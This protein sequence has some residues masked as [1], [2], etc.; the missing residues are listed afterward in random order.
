MKKLYI[1]FIL[2]TFG[3]SP[4][5][6]A[7][8]TLFSDD[9]ESGYVTDTSIDGIN[10]WTKSE[11]GMTIKTMNS[12]GN[13]NSSSDWYA[14]YTTG[15]FTIMQIDFNVEA[16]K[17]YTFK[18]YSYKTG[19]GAT[20]VK[21]IDAQAVEVV[22]GPTSGTADAWVERKETFVASKTETLT[23]QCVQNWGGGTI[24]IDDV[25]LIC[26]DCTP[27]SIEKFNAFE[28][29]AYP[30]PVKDVFSIQS[31][32]IL[33][34][35]MVYDMLGRKVIDQKSNF[36]SI[37]MTNLNNGIYMLKLEAENGGLSTKKIIK[38]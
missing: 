32:E 4:M 14:E 34:N 31:Q 24:K 33:I 35:A 19:A 36:E 29:S 27:L 25:S 11:T 15:A 17:S 8:T 20:R 37:D 7:Q 26:N 3:I 23:F 16:G 2:M 21:I 5:V 18:F 22:L 38:N 10:G 13:G 9:F 28:F 12:S 30:N 1:L 6:N